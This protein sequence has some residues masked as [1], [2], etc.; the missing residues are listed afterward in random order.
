MAEVVPEPVRGDLDAALVATA[1]DDLVDPT[2]RH[3]S[4][5]VDAEPQLRAVGQGVP[6]TDAEVPDQQQATAEPEARQRAAA[7]FAR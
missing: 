7:D 3:R 5:V 6:S 2:G 4:P 1:D